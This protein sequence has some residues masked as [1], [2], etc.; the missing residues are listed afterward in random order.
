MMMI[1]LFYFI[2]CNIN[3]STVGERNTVTTL[4][5]Q[6]KFCSSHNAF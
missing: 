4:G 1:I 3:W 5:N 2:F 6:L